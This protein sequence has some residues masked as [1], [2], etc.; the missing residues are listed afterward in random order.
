ML[1]HTSV[2]SRSVE[3]STAT[4][5]PTLS[6]TPRL[7]VRSTTLP[8]QTGAAASTKPSL[9]IPP[10]ASTVSK[11]WPSPKTSSAL[12]PRLSVTE[13]WVFHISSAV[14]LHL[15]AAE[16]V[17][18]RRLSAKNVTME[19]TMVFWVILALSAASAFLVVRLVMELVFL[20]S[21][22]PHRHLAS[23]FP[24]LMAIT[25]RKL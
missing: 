10:S 8:C 18:G 17:S 1:S 6:P 22:A 16:T 14:E 7:S 13:L 24:L 5:K 15:L 2:T 3:I 4:T 21:S 20:L 9:S 19:R 11:P 25:P 23:L 12:A